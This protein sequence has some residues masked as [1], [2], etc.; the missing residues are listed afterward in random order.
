MR[1]LSKNQVNFLRQEINLVRIEEQLKVKKTQDLI[2]KFNNKI[3]REVCS[4]ISN[5]FWHRKQHEVEL[6]YEPSFSEK[7]IPTTAKPI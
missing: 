2:E 7:N 6:P 1:K 4:N 5:V 3:V